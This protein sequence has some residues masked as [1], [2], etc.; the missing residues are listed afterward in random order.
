MLSF[1]K[2]IVNMGFFYFG[3][4]YCMH[5]AVG[6]SPLR[7]PMVVFGILLYH[8]A[9]S[10]TKVIDLILIF[11]L[12]IL[13]QIIDTIYIQM[14]MISYHG[15]YGG[16]FEIAP[17]WIVAL[18]ALYGTSVNHSLEWLR[19]SVLLAAGLGAAG[20]ISSYV[21]GVQL[22]SAVLHWPKFWAYAVIGGVWAVV[23]PLSLSFSQWL[24]KRYLA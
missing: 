20:A 15:G 5:E 8:I 19:H 1:L 4:W 2:R 23:V 13:G 21:V 10:H 22:G 12:V 24:K 11:S 3:W 6:L 9:I 18:W 16:T 14:G 7:G 17:L